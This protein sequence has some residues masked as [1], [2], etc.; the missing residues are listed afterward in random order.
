M[1]L[2]DDLLLIAN[3]VSKGLLYARSYPISVK[4]DKIKIVIPTV[5]EILENEELYSGIVTAVT[6][7][8]SD[9][10]VQLD[11]FGIDFSKISSFDLFLLLFK[12]LQESDTSLV[13]GDLDLSKFEKVVNCQNGHV[14]L[15]DKE[16]GIIID[17]AI[18]DQ[19]CRLLRKINHLEKHDR[20]PANEEA[21]KYMLERARIKQR[22][23]LQQ[24]GKSQLEDLIVALVNTEQYKYDYEG[25]LGLTIYQFNASAYQIIK[26]INYDNTMIGCYAGTVNIKNLSQDDLNW[27]STK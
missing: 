16:N 20:K 1:A 8:P 13:F 24:S 9:F 26:K 10:M 21:K 27:L 19:I 23:A 25:T 2:Q 4:N 5:G 6:A 7:T 14:V 17:R 15:K 22:R 12:S 3:S 18:H 11:D